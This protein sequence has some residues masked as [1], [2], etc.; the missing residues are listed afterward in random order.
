[1]SARQQKHWEFAPTPLSFMRNKDGEIDDNETE[2][3]FW[4]DSWEFVGLMQD[5]FECAFKHL[6]ILNFILTFHSVVSLFLDIWLCLQHFALDWWVKQIEG[7]KEQKPKY[8][9]YF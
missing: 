4:D 5:L 6:N 8:K 3:V 1:M 7:E 9:I 2:K